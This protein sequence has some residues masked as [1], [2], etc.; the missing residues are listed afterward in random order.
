MHDSVTQQTGTFRRR[1]WTINGPSQRDGLQLLEET[2]ILPFAPLQ[3]KCVIISWT[4]DIIRRVAISSLWRAECRTV[5]GQIVS[6]ADDISTL[7]GVYR[8][9]AYGSWLCLSAILSGSAQ[10]Y[11]RTAK[12]ENRTAYLVLQ[13]REGRR[14]NEWST[15]QVVVK[16]G[17]RPVIYCDLSRMTLKISI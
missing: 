12:I 10:Q 4:E 5:V 14:D 15:A 2:Q 6:S 9:L 3:T 13:S 1:L 8:H 16:W 17:C 7:P 11:V